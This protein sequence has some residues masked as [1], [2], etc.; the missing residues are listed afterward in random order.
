MSAFRRPLVLLLLGLA[1]LAGSASPARG[2]THDSKNALW[3]EE[4]FAGMLDAYRAA[5]PGKLRVLSFELVAVRAE[6]Q[7]Q[8]PAKPKHVD[9]YN[10]EHGRVIGPMPVKL[11]GSGK[12]EDNLYDWDEVAWETIPDLVKQTIK[13]VRMEHGHVGGVTVKRD[14]PSHPRVEIL[15]HV[16]GTR[17]EG[18]L[19]ADAKGN[20]LE[21][22]KY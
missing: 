18:E 11:Y 9:Q 7:V 6:L 2:K 3:H 21:A 19:R 13:K 1:A 15:V 14:L 22:H 4:N 20:V 12:L 16:S 17:E 8:D 5:L 10:Y